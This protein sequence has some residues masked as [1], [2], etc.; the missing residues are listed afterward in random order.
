MVQTVVRD[1]RYLYR[2]TLGMLLVMIFTS[3]ISKPVKPSVHLFSYDHAEAKSQMFVKALSDGGYRIHVSGETM[4]QGVDRPTMI[5]PRLV[6]AVEILDEIQMAAED[7]GLARLDVAVQS[8]GSHFYDTEHI[9]IYI[10]DPDV[11]A[12]AVQNVSSKLIEYKTFLGDCEA[13]DIEL[14]LFAGNL[15]LMRAYSWDEEVETETIENLPG[16]WLL[17]DGLLLVELDN[18]PAA[19][20][21]VR[22]FED[23]IETGIYSGIQLR[24]ISSAS[25]FD[26]CDFEYRN[27]KPRRM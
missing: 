9:G 24:H 19:K 5:I 4:P 1:F 11:I 17:D 25:R 23:R 12:D 21:E 7:S 10:P 3:C 2:S 15:S 22:E 20:Y 16:T 26:S 13:E 6:R 8:A 14:N 27:F 18:V